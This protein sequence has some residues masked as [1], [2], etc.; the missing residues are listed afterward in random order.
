[1]DVMK[2]LKGLPVPSVLAGGLWS[3]YAGS[4]GD[5][6]FVGELVGELDVALFNGKVKYPAVFAVFCGLTIAWFVHLIFVVGV[7]RRRNRARLKLAQLRDDGV[8]LRL[9]GQFLSDE[10]SVEPWIG[11]L[12]DWM[13]EVVRCI[14]KIDEADAVQYATLDHPGEPRAWPESIQSQSHRSHYVWHDRRLVLL[15]ELITK[16]G[17]QE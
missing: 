12:R 10:P 8:K 7:N 2:V 5:W 6:P 16:Y 15:N 14:K 1:M 11:K 9:E 13:A 17:E 4:I 3:S